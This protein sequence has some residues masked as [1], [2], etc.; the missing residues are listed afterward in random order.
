MTERG[1]KIALAISV[2]VNLFVAGVVVTGLAVGARHLRDRPYHDRPPVISM[3]R[4]LDEADRAAAEDTLRATALAARDDFEAARRLRSEAIAQ[5]GAESFDR[6]AIEATLA[7]SRASEA[8]GRMRLEGAMLDLLQS[9]DQDDR[10][11]LAPALG[12]RARGEPM[13][14]PA[15]PEG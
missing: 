8:A 12:R 2:A 7:R 5:A 1:L 9:L 11:R 10:Q 6:A 13:E 15:S 4:S 3:I 14:A